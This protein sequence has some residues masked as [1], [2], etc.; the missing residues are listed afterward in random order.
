VNTPK[1]EYSSTVSSPTQKR[2][3]RKK[4]KSN[5]EHNLSSIINSSKSNSNIISSNQSDTD[6]ETSSATSEPTI[7]TNT[8]NEYFNNS[9]DITS[10]NTNKK[11]NKRTNS[12]SLLVTPT[13]DLSSPSVEVTLAK[14]APT[15][16]TTAK[17]S[18][19]FNSHTTNATH[20]MNLRKWF[21]SLAEEERC[22]AVSI[23]DKEFAK[24]LLNMYG[25]KNKEGDG[26]FF[27]VGTSDDI[28]SFIDN[29][30]TSSNNN[31]SRTNSGGTPYTKKNAIRPRKLSGGNSNMHSVNG[32]NTNSKRA[33]AA[34]NKLGVPSGIN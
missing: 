22:S 5:S 4:K 1:P 34:G 20:T 32:N 31:R 3:R 19:I 28:L 21:A 2:R 6:Y 14:S 16:P 24:L 29:K 7:S 33:N 18:L 12:V 17:R 10:G 8:L 15:S 30:S 11:T 25:K 27:E 26:L 13:A 23:V 9:N